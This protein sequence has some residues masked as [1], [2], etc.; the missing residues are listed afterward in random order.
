MQLLAPISSAATGL[1]VAG[2]QMLLLLELLLEVTDVG[3]PEDEVVEE[4]GAGN[5]GGL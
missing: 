2:L 1:I 4:W 3:G 5:D